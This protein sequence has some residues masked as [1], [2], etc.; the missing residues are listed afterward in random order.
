LTK[1]EAGPSDLTE[2]GTSI[3]KPAEE[4][5]KVQQLPTVKPRLSGAARRKLRKNKEEQSGTGSLK[6]LGHETS[7]KAQDSFG[8]WVI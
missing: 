8:A 6:R 3:G 4:D 7:K 5:I 1:P 2:Q